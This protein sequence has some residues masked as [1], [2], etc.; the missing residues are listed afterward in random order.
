LADRHTGWF[1]DTDSVES[2]RVVERTL[3]YHCLTSLTH[4]HSLTQT[5]VAVDSV[6]TRPIEVTWVTGTLIDVHLT[7]YTCITC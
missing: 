5:L 4:E 2:T 7:V 1:L 3:T 6:N